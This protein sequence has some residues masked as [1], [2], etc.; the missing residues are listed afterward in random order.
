MTTIPEAMRVCARAARQATSTLDGRQLV[1]IVIT[2]DG[3]VVR[4]R[5][6]DARDAYQ[7]HGDVSWREFENFP[8]I[9]LNVTYGVIGQLDARARELGHRPVVDGL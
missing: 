1:E 8:A 3:I 7:A 5:Y 9:L 4:G 6:S 2:E